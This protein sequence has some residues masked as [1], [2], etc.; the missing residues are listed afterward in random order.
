MMDRR[1]MAG[2]AV[3]AL[4]L[5]AM[6][7]VPPP[8]VAGP[9]EATAVAERSGAVDALFSPPSPDTIPGDLRGEQIRLGYKMVCRQYAQLHELSP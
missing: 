1:M 3:V 6:G 7:C 8:R 4:F 2:T 5:V 9:E